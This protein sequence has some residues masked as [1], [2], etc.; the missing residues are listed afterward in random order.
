MTN[1]LPALV[2]A[3]AALTLAAPGH[4][5]PNMAGGFTGRLP[6]GTEE[7][8]VVWDV[9]A[10]PDGPT[11]TLNG[12]VQSVHDQL[13][14]INPNYEGDF[15]DHPLEKRTDWT[16]AGILCDRNLFGG[17]RP[18][19]YAEAIR[20]LRRLRGRPRMGPG[21]RKCGRVSC[22]YLTA[23][24]LCNDTAEEKRLE[25][26][27]SVVSGIEAIWNKCNPSQCC[28]RGGQIFHWTHWNIMMTSDSC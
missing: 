6:E 1:V 8:P 5:A 4:G 2:L 18:K 19:G 25:S 22:S 24:W 13:R 9:Q 12:T 23:I 3:L 15:D 27:N 28:Y 21:P 17:T 11:L 26:W 7:T 16:G 10:F 20:Y 14:A